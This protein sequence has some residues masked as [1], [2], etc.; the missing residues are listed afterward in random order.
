MS[1]PAE[2]FNSQFPDLEMP[3]AV[4]ERFSHGTLMIAAFAGW[5]DAG[6]A[7]TNALQHV[8]DVFEGRLFDEL[9]PE[10]YVDFQVNR[11]TIVNT[12]AGK[13]IL[14]PSTRVEIVSQ[15]QLKRDLVLVHGVEPSMRWKTYYQTILRIADDLGC[16]GIVLLGSLVGEVSHL[17]K[18]Q[19]SV[20]TSNEFLQ[21]FF[22]LDESDYEGPTG[23][24]GVLAHYAELDGVPTVSIW[25]EVPHYAPNPPSI[26]AEVSLVEALEELTGIAIPLGELTD[27]LHAWERGVSAFVD[28]DPELSQYVEQLQETPG[29]E[30]VSGD[31]IAQEFERFLKRRSNLTAADRPQ[32]ESPDP[33]YIAG[34]TSSPAL[35]ES[36]ETPDSSQSREQEEAPAESNTPESPDSADQP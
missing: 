17:A 23:I 27:E 12:E 35:A 16:A 24:N 31:S 4:A 20:T 30:Q 13:H 10:P 9:D 36:Q 5:N 29:L 22:E 3:S 32:T 19:V 18:H 2:N 14:W 6:S 26:R 11:P 33:T 1:T 25:A 15:P 34:P 21:E 7:A 28:S 8:S